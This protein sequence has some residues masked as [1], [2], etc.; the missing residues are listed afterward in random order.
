MTFLQML[1]PANW[2]WATSPERPDS[3]RS[4]DGPPYVP[5]NEYDTK[6]P[7]EPRPMQGLWTTLTVEQ[8]TFLAAFNQPERHLSKRP[9]PVKR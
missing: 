7:G 2:G 5:E 9:L 6:E 8:R 4:D 1:S 3:G